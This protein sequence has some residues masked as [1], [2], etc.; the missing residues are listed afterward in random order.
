MIGPALLSTSTAWVH[1]LNTGYRLCGRSLFRR[2]FLALFVWVVL[3]GSGLG[4]LWGSADLFSR[5]ATGE[6]ITKTVVSKWQA[7]HLVHPKR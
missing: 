7:W 4:F 1:G 3:V 6:E 2:F 5:L